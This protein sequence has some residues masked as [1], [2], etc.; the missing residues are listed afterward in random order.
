MTDFC[1]WW[2]DFGLGGI[3]EPG[4]SGRRLHL[5]GVA[6]RALLPA[7]GP[8]VFVEVCAPAEAPATGGARVGPLSR[9]RPA[10]GAEVRAVAEALPALS[11][12]V[13]PLPSVR[14]AVDD[15]AGALAEAL[16]ALGAPVGLLARVD[17]LVGTEVGAVAEA[18][19]AHRTLVRPLPSV[20]ALVLG[21]VGRFAK[22]FAAFRACVWLCHPSRT[23]SFQRPLGHGQAPHR[24]LP[25][26]REW[27]SGPPALLQQC[28]VPFRSHWCVLPGVLSILK[29]HLKA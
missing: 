24:G 8:L 27:G 9:V 26:T 15:Q 23:L 13:G 16:P 28:L 21:Q 29:L 20:C 4:G 14:P 11:A 18:L 25:L 19:P 2:S 10:V 12:H 1:A 5:L 3:L 22:A 7:M 17:A 6:P